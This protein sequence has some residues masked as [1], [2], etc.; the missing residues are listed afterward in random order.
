M[1]PII[2]PSLLAA[3]FTK[4][5]ED[6]KMIDNSDADWL[7]LDV[8]DG[9]FVPNI[10]FGPAIIKSIRHLKLNKHIVHLCTQWRL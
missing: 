3:D 2:A 5:A 1:N 10:S 7:H 6:V 8:M 9:M 4:L